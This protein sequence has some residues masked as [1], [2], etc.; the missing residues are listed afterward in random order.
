MSYEKVSSIAA[1]S[2]SILSGVATVFQ[3][4]PTALGC[5]A[6][7]TGITLSIVLICCHIKKGRLERRLLEIQIKEHTKDYHENIF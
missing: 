5:V 6:S 4:I 7:I 3:Y 2:G 1:S